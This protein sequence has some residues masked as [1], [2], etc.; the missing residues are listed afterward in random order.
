M[1][2]SRILSL[3]LF[4][5]TLC[6]AA[7]LKI[8]VVDPQSAV[9][10]GARV[11][12][13][14]ASGSKPVAVRTVSA[15]GTLDLSGLKPG[16]YRVQVLAPGFAQKTVHVTIPSEQ[17]LV[18][19]LSIAPAS[20]T[21]VVSAAATPV[22]QGES[23]TAVSVLD[24]ATVTT[25]NPPD[26]GDALRFTP[27]VV[28]ANAGRTGG[29]STLFVR[30]GESRYNKVII[31]GVPSN[32][33]GGTFDFGVVPVQ[34]VERIEVLRGAASSLYGSDA[35]TSV[36]QLWSA[37]GSTRVPELT[38]GADGGTFGTAHGYAALAGSR[39]RF[40]YNLFGDQFNTNG[41]GIND[42]YSNSSQGANLGFRLADHAS[43]RLRTRHSNSRTGVPSSWWFNGAE[44]IAPDSDQYARQNNFLSSLE[45]S[46]NAPGNWQHHITG[47]EYN[48]YRKNADSFSDP[49]RPF[50]DPFDSRTSFNRAGLQYTAE[51][52]PRQWTRTVFGYY[53]EDE[54]EHIDDNFISF[55]FPGE[56]HTPGSRQNQ[57]LF[58]EQ[59][60]NWK[61]FTL[62]AG[63]RY[64]HNES[65]GNKVLPRA[66]VT[67]L[68]MPGGT[69][70]SG[71]RL[72]FSYSEGIKAPTF[73]ET[74]GVTG[75]FF[76][77]PNPDLLPER[78]RTF[79]TGFQQGFFSGRYSLAGTY[80][81]N[82]FTDQIQFKFDPVASQFININK[83]LAHGAE[84][85][86]S[87]RVSNRVRLDS[88]YT[89]T[90]T[91]AESSP[92]CLPGSGCTATGEPLLRR[93]KHSGQMLLTYLSTN[94]GGSLAGT[95]VGRRPDSDFL[96]GFIS[97]IDHAA[98]Y[99][100]LDVSAWHTLNHHTTAYVTV[101]NFL[102]KRYNDVLGYPGLKANFRAGLRFRVGGE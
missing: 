64:E 92:N 71:T 78:T 60:V 27:G 67:F 95:F 44:T 1:R 62:L 15:D 86:F 68:A 12:V 24:G 63:A 100:R 7:D 28:V 2:I 70:L 11:T 53:F 4:L 102:N 6:V 33:P 83:A 72:R 54:N 77:I 50:D 36:V 69:L 45:L 8:R 99:A 88:S 91:Q 74:F 5:S 79:E 98:G 84:L 76:T 20:E 55:G 56:T 39:D 101:G 25:L 52:D 40:D 58:G 51:Y 43:L 35:M 81:N 87:G 21:V 66:T 94:W 42:E 89:Y 22:P 57:A 65:F 80:F 75:T 93:P 26:L 30:G 18:V 48:H 59:F 41:Q 23:G 32:D 13:L 61:R 17:V 19:Q 49:G 90:S 38:F 96:F 85:E 16:S 10:P 46:I 37:S 31:D 29:L 73:E 9:V 82:H 47:F 97:P 14:A 3:L 34:E